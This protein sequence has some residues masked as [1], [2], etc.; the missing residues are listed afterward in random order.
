MFKK[1][2]LFLFLGIF[3][4]MGLLKNASCSDEPSLSTYDK[5]TRKDKQPGQELLAGKDLTAFKNFP[6]TEL[7]QY[8]NFG[9]GEGLPEITVS[10]LTEENLSQEVSGKTF[11]GVTST[12]KSYALYFD[13]DHDDSYLQMA[14]GRFEKGTYWLDTSGLHVCFPTIHKGTPTT[15]KYF[16][17]RHSD[18]YVLV[19]EKTKGY[20]I[21]V[22]KA[23]DTENLKKKWPTPSPK[24]HQKP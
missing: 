2:A 14:D 16:R 15:V 19:N 13:P 23:G 3:S 18:C 9:N 12:L 8:D 7:K 24:E 4:L 17:T 6:V 20:G 21:M 5:Y 1:T 22:S 10:A 11:Y